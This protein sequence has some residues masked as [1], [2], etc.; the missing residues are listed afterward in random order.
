MTKKNKGGNDGNKRKTRGTKETKERKGPGK[1][2]PGRDKEA[3]RGTRTNTATVLEEGRTWDPEKLKK[4]LKELT[5]EQQFEFR[6]I[7]ISRR[8]GEYGRP[9][10]IGE[11]KTYTPSTKDIE[12]YTSVLERK[13]L[14]DL[15]LMGRV[16][17]TTLK[18]DVMDRMKSFDK[19]QHAVV[20]IFN[21]NQTSDTG[22]INCYD[23]T[24]TRNEMTYMVMNERG[25]HDPEF[26]M[27]HFYYYANHVCPI[28]FQKGKL[29]TNAY[30]A[31]L[32]S[33][34][35]RMKVIEALAAID[36]EKYIKILLILAAVTTVL[37]GVD[38]ITI[39]K[40]A[41][42]MGVG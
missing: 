37:I 32:I 34:T 11:G 25:V 4:A 2:E 5:K 9:L 40:I 24:F 17:K 22:V 15:V 42:S 1:Q 7:I 8:L 3:G 19:K 30:D 10:K 33:A 31:K 38:T 16:L 36:M 14:K 26:K 18:L 27:M 23:R 35:I 28:F 21:D 12:E 41:K 29:P 20:T 39:Y 13:K 6:S